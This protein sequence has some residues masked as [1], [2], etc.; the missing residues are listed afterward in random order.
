MS[1]QAIQ[2]PLTEEEKIQQTRAAALQIVLSRY[3]QGKAMTECLQ[4]AELVMKWLYDGNLPK[5]LLRE[6]K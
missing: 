2:S 4:E 3:P 6:V 1:G 5:S